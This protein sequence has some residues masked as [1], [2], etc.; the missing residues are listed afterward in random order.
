[1]VSLVVIVCFLSY[2]CVGKV[3]N[4]ATLE[5]SPNETKLCFPGVT[6]PPSARLFEVVFKAEFVCDG[7]QNRYDS[8]RSEKGE[9]DLVENNCEHFINYLIT[10]RHQSFTANRINKVAQSKLGLIQNGTIL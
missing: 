1:M 5:N 2:T 10:G 7:F 9:W 8:F 4:L 3:G 6:V